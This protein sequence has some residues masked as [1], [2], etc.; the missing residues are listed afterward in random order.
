MRRLELAAML[1]VL[2]LGCGNVLAQVTTGTISGTV[3]DSTGAVIP[4]TTVRVKNVET[5]AVRTVTTDPAGRYSAPQLGV[6]RYEVAAEAAGF[7]AVVRSG[8]DLTLGREAAVDF[9]LQIGSVSEQVTVTG[10][11]PLV[12]T[13]NSTVANLVSE[14]AM[15]ELPLNGRSF[16]DLTALSP[17]VVTDLGVPSGVFQGGGRMADRKSTRLNS[18]HIQK[19][20]MPSSA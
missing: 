6:G 15:R 7:Q 3:K 1:L 13:T 2:A 17:G 12:E 11:A 9:T 5:G 20:R 14:K 10:E 8:I 19:S 16:T 18:S 4:A